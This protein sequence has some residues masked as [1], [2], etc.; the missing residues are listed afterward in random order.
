MSR[1]KTFTGVSPVVSTT[2]GLVTS[3]PH[4]ADWWVPVLNGKPVKQGKLAARYRTKREAEEALRIAKAR[5]APM[6]G[7]K[8]GRRMEPKS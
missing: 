4:Q 6:P 1:A 7:Y 2:R 3:E 8:L 5:R